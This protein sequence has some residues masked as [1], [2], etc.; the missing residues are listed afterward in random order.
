MRSSLLVVAAVATA[1][2]AATPAF[3]QQTGRGQGT[4]REEDSTARRNRQRSEWET[5]QARLNEDRNSGP[6]PFVKVLYD[7]GRYIDF[8]GGREAATAVAWTGEI[9]GVEASC[10][11]RDGQPIT[12][13]L[14]VA[15]T[16]GRGPTA[17]GQAKSYRWWVAVTERNRTVIAKEYF[18]LDARFRPGQDRLAAA[19]RLGGITIPRKD[20]KVSGSNF[21]IL[22]GFDVTPAMAE[23]NREGKRFRATAGEQAVKA[24]AQTGQ[25]AAR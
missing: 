22:V 14:D 11:Y 2:T 8:A 6:C 7:A 25:T 17:Q 5:P 20:D 21:E 12:V 9:Q 13:D 18:A 4:G 15:F 16:L 19:E 23:F 3:A 10:R 1:L 24:P